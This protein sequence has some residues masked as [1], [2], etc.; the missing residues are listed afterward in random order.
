MRKGWVVGAVVRLIFIVLVVVLSFVFIFDPIWEAHG[1][2]ECIIYQSEVISNLKSSIE[3]VK[4]TGGTIS[5]GF[6]VAQCVEC[7]WYNRHDGTLMVNYAV[8]SSLISPIYHQIVPYNVSA[9]FINLGCNCNDCNDPSGCS[10]INETKLYHFFVNETSVECTNCDDSTNPCGAATVYSPCGIDQD[11]Y[12][13]YVCSQDKDPL[14]GGKCY[15]MD[16]IGNWI[17]FADG[18][19]WT[20]KNCTKDYGMSCSSEK[21]C[22]IYSG[23]NIEIHLGCQNTRLSSDK[24]CC[25]PLI[26]KSY[27]GNNGNC[28]DDSPSSSLSCNSTEDCNKVCGNTAC[29]YVYDQNALGFDEYF[30]CFFLPGEECKYDWQCGSSNKAIRSSTQCSKWDNVECPKHA[31]CNWCGCVR[32]T[33]TREGVEHCFCDPSFVKK[34]DCDTQ[35]NTMYVWYYWGGCEG[36]LTDIGIPTTCSSGKCCIN[37]GHSCRIADEDF[38]DKKYCCSSDDIIK[39]EKCCIPEGI[40]CIDNL[41]CCSGVC[42]G[43]ICIADNVPPTYDFYSDDAPDTVTPKTLIKVSALWSDNGLLKTGIFKHNESGI[44]NSDEYPFTTNPEWFDVSIMIGYVKGNVCWKQEAKDMNDTL[45]DTMPLNCTK[46]I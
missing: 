20:Y 37:S 5:R 13:G 31:G 19:H 7:I 10:N 44:W 40:N 32:C 14:T 12:K 2:N 18:S 43:G 11:C 33:Q 26:C 16:T 45:N 39:D 35:S 24:T 23:N 29:G 9:Q 1:Y 34:S 41:Q 25:L 21:E 15:S 22:S 3:T 4:K 42:S 30:N 46:V 8:K 17:E 36:E 38:C 27:S 6:D 28:N